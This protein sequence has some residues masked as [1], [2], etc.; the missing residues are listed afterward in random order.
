M[1]LAN[2]TPFLLFNSASRQKEAFKPIDP[3]NVRFYSCGPTVY[4]YAHIGNMRAFLCADVLSRTLHHKG[5]T[6]TFVQNITDVGHLTDDANDGEDKVESRAK[7]ERT[8]AYEIS[9]FYL[10]AFIEDAHKLNLL[11]PDARPRATEYIPEQIAFIRELEERGFAYRTEDGIYF[12]TSKI[13]G[14]G[15]WLANIYASEDHARIG[16]KRGKRHPADFALWKF[17]PEGGKRDMEWE[18]PWGTGFPGWHIECSAISRKLLDFPF[19][20]HMGG[21]DHAAIHHTN[22]IAQNIAATGARAV[23]VWLHNEFVTVENEKMSKSKENIFTVRDIENRGISPL[24]Y[25]YMV[26]NAHY[27][28]IL[29]FT[30]DALEA[31]ESGYR[32][33]LDHAHRLQSEAAEAKPSL[34]AMRKEWPTAKHARQDI[35]KAFYDDLNTPKALGMIWNLIKNEDIEAKI[36]LDALLD[37]DRILG[38]GIFRALS[39]AEDIPERIQTLAKKRE[40]LRNERKFEEA[41]RV[42]EQIRKEGYDVEDTPRGPRILPRLSGRAFHSSTT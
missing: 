39:R 20:I 40:M 32:N 25:R 24:A 37:A 31:A 7:K 2:K 30:W 10:N 4:D 19:D 35:M 16:K 12:D 23:R 9:D 41:D 14:Y 6:V 22:E 3:K 42:R 29:N 8:T 17:S 27:R 15:S 11:D 38:L 33:L 13:E 18:S 5:Y 1:V 26:L 34:T 28:Q 21:I 36:R